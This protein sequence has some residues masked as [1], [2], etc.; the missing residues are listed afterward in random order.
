MDQMYVCEGSSD[1]EHAVLHDKSPQS[2]TTLNPNTYTALDPSSLIF[3]F[4]TP[5]TLRIKLLYNL[6]NLNKRNVVMKNSFG[7]TQ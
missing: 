5:L 7:L 1:R 4:A 2:Q 3:R 6:V